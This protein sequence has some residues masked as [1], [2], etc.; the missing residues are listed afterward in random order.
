MVW[1]P[2]SA[3]SS[4]RFDPIPF[5]DVR[6]R[7]SCGVWTRWLAEINCLPRECTEYHGMNSFG[8][9]IERKQSIGKVSGTRFQVSVVNRKSKGPRVKVSNKW[10]RSLKSVY[11]NNIK[12]Y[13]VNQTRLLIGL[14]P[15]TQWQ[16]LKAHGSGHTAHGK[17]RNPSID[18]ENF[19]W[20]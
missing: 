6:G 19:L 2:F 9:P 17:K 7:F 3:S 15:W 20:N 8:T 5:R 16:K 12:L 11:K 10:I 18:D 4:A 1:I 13:A 14:W